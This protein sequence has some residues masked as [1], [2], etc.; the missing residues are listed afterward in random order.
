MEQCYNVV[1][2][3]G[4]N[5]VIIEFNDTLTQRVFGAII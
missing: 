4:T 1:T 3:T 2:M 5:N